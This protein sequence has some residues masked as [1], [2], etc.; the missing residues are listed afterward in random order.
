MRFSFRK[1]LRFLQGQRSWTLLRRLPTGKLQLEDDLGTIELLTQAEL[2]ERWQTRTW[3]IDEAC[4]N[5]HSNVFYFAT[6]RDLASFSEPQ[7]TDVRWRLS[8]LL[9]QSV[10]SVESTPVAAQNAN[11]IATPAP[12][13]DERKPPHRTTRYRW[14]VRFGQ[15][16]DATA[17]VDQRYR[18]GR[19][20]NKK[21]YGFFE[22]AL[23]TVYLT[24]QKRPK[25]TVFQEMTRQITRFNASAAPDKQV[26]PAV[27]STVYLWLDCLDAYLVDKS[28]LGKD[29]ADRKHRG[30]IGTVLPTNIL[31]RVEI[32][33]SPLDL[34][35]IDKVTLIPIGR[36]WLTVAIDRFSRAIL[37][38]YLTF[39]APSSLSVLQ[40]LKRAVLPKDELLKRFPGVKN[41]WPMHGFPEEIFCDNGMDLHSNG[42]AKLCFEMGVRITYCPAAMPYYKGSVERIF[43]TIN[44]GLIHHLPGTVFSNI[45]QRGDYP[46]EK[47]A[48]LDLDE[49]THLLTKWIVDVYH[50]TPHTV[51]KE[52]PID[53]WNKSLATRIIELPAYPEQLDV[54]VGI[55]DTR[56]LFHYGIEFEGLLYNNAELQN[57]RQRKDERI[58]IDFK[59]YE[60]DISYVHVWDKDQKEYVRVEVAA[61]FSEYAQGLT[62]HMH[63]VI[64]AHGQ[65]KW[66][67]K[68][69]DVAPLIAKQEIQ[70][71]VLAAQVDKKMAQRKKAAVLTG[72]HS[73]RSLDEGSA[74][75]QAI[76]KRQTARLT[77]P[78][79]LDPGLDDELP[80]FGLSHTQGHKNVRT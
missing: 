38:F 40:C 27:R 60:D 67:E 23:E 25:I 68:W 15:A 80:I 70:D 73:E 13:L 14:R 59:H 58:K 79:P 32:D 55:P 54:L 20:P 19:R 18:S 71:I 7:R 77:P 56:T 50:Q 43:R 21:T 57:L 62:R 12:V 36:P 37:G 3:V 44:E 41:T 39:N 69:Q 22:D 65:R 2:L 72:V 42:V 52:R 74:L 64:H 76:Q 61:R 63:R 17:L 9:D 33:H 4:L 29:A 30:A 10:E 31:E 78:I 34:L 24:D 51:T 45:V 47:A 6:P 8:H 26:K 28:R 53:L 5:E 75:D 1:G 49:I 48:T 35:V 46:A 16:K 66:G 11:E